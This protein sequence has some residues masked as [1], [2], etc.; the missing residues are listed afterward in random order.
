M[1]LFK[2]KKIL[3]FCTDIN[4]GHIN[5]PSDMSI[6]KTAVSTTNDIDEKQAEIKEKS[7]SSQSVKIQNSLIIATQ[8]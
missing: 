1:I 7:C 6:L 5:S 2:M 8:A 3:D 4:C